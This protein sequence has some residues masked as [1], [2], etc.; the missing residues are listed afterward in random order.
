MRFNVLR[1]TQYERFEIVFLKKTNHE[2][3][4]ILVN[5]LEC[6]VYLAMDFECKI[7]KSD[8]VK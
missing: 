7:L 6:Q 1:N 4:S 8:L 3:L 2:Y 5:Y